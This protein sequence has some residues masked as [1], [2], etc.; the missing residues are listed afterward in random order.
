VVATPRVTAELVLFA[1]EVTVFSPSG[2]WGDPRCEFVRPHAMLRHSK[3]W[4]R[5]APA[6]SWMDPG[7]SPSSLH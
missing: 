2:T 6:M 7:A 4:Q 1:C 3:D 5:S